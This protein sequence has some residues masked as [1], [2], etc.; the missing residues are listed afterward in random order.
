MVILAPAIVGRPSAAELAG[1]L[2]IELDDAGFFRTR[3]DE[4]LPTATSRE[5]VYAAGC[6]IGPTDIATSVA[7]AAEAVGAILK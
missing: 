6:A 4:L 3:L 1:V 7:Q 2:G 5:G